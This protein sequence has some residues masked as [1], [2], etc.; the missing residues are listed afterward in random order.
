MNY[1]IAGFKKVKSASE[2]T[3][4]QN[5]NLR[6][7]L[8][9][10]EQKRIDGNRSHLNKVLTN[11]LGSDEKDP[12]SFGKK[13]REFYKSQNIDVRKDSVLAVDLVLTTSPEYFGDWHQ[14]G[15]ITK[16]GQKKID[17]W[18][19]TQI[20]FLER[21]FGKEAVKLA[22][23]HLDETT[24]HIHVVV[25]PE[26]KKIRNYKNQHG[27]FT[28]ESSQLN[29]NRWSPSFW[30][31]NFLKNYAKANAKFGLK[32]GVEGSTKKN[33]PLKEFSALV[34]DAVNKDYCKALEKML[35]E[36]TDDLS[37][38]N[39][40]AGVEKLIREKLF[41]QLELMMKGNNALKKL[42]K[43]DRLQEY[44]ANKKA[45]EELEE[46]KRALELDR[47]KTDEMQAYYGKGLKIRMALEEK[48]DN[49]MKE[50]SALKARNQELEELI[51]AKTTSNNKEKKYG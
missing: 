28:K 12:S 20:E 47:K 43:K 6:I 31:N 27:T 1:C 48:L 49:A 16:D 37:V 40:K 4:M 11:T 23:L 10:A 35:A 9:Q 5:H 13:L 22:V 3:Q 25:T 51:P 44:H 15:A 39:T 19:K 18:V 50:I 29:A 2:L 7:H 46:S 17:E 34:A 38:L 14:N 24:P 30:K 26:E 8:T 45:L 21:Q 33:V 32:R 36:L 41:P 42:V